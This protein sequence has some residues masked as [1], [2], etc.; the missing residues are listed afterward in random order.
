MKVLLATTRTV[1]AH[2]EAY[3]AAWSQLQEQARQSGVHAWLF[4]AMNDT[5]R[6]LEFLEWNQPHGSTNALPAELYAPLQH[7]DS[8]GPA[9]SESWME[10]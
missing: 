8:F 3:R 10:T 1:T 6:Y 4:R 2:T 5:T 7:L 9:T